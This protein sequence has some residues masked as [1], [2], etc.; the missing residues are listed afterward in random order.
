MIRKKRAIRAQGMESIDFMAVEGKRESRHL[1]RECLRSA[2]P[3]AG[4]HLVL[5]PVFPVLGCHLV[6]R[7]VFPVAECC[8]VYSPPH[9]NKDTLV[10]RFWDFSP[11]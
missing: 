5:R 3:V 7:P 10:T 11:K 2:S 1:R 8:P 4:C 9:I 6:L